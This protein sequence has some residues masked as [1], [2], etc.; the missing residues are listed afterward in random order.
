MAIPA[1]M[2][3]ARAS[4]GEPR[5]PRHRITLKASGTFAGGGPANVTVHNVSR[6][7]MLLEC[8]SSLPVDEILM[9]DLPGAEA[10]QAKVVW[11]SDR[12]H[13]CEFLE[14]VSKAV[15]SA[16][17]LRSAVGS[18]LKAL[19][20]GDA[21]SGEPFGIR[22]Q[23]LR[24]ERGLSLAQIA[25]SLAVSKPTVWAWEQGRTRP[26]Q[27]RIDLLAQV[28]G[29]SSQALQTGRDDEALREVLERSRRQIADAFGT[30]TSNV[31]I[32]IEL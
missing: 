23:R 16:A 28:L 14:P 25:S 18:D 15:L 32:M 31:R 26:A 27:E 19:E 6:T 11:T 24:K 5:D 20:H 12:L 22:L 2:E 10:T 3:E 13:G 17:Q 4:S 29:T 7:G 8:D 21:D 9:I 30:E 1:R